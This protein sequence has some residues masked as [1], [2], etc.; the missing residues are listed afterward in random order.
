MSVSFMRSELSSMLLVYSIIRDCIEGEPAIKGWLLSGTN[1][2]QNPAGFNGGGANPVLSDTIL[3]RARR[4]LPMPNETDQSQ[5]NK[6]RY[7]QYLQRAVWYNVTARTLEGMV[8]QIFLIPPVIEVPSELKPMLTDSDGDGLSFVQGAKKS[9]SDTMAYGRCGLYVD[10]PKTSGEVNKAQISSGAIKPMIQVI[11]P[12]NIYNWRTKKINGKTVLT[13]VVIRE[14]SDNYDEDGYS[15]DQS[16]GYRVL[17]LDPSTG[18]YTIEV[19]EPADARDGAVNSITDPMVA[20]ALPSKANVAYNQSDTIVP[21]DGAGKPFTYIPFTFVGSKNNDPA[22]DKP[23]LYDLASLNLAHYR[24]SADFE[25]SCHMVGQPTP[26]ATGLDESWVHNVLHDSIPLG[27]RAGIPLPTGA[28]IG[29]MQAN[30]NQMPLEAM[31]AKEDEMFALGAKLVVQKRVQ[32]TATEAAVDAS[33][34]TS[35]LTNVAN[36]VSTAYEFAF[37]CAAQFV[38]A[39]ASKIKVALNTQFELN[40]LTPDEQSKVVASWVQGAISFGEMRET[41]RKA[42]T[43]TLPDDQARAAIEKDRKDGLIPPAGGAKLATNAPNPNNNPSGHADTAA[44]AG[45]P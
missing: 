42:G 25:E 3:L 8:G 30:A 9:V 35:V 38:N 39:D 18:N 43:A 14:V 2:T 45:R 17:K 22:V 21:T 31:K 12:W 29:L 36:N 19:Y 10:Y 44:A 33:S 11:Q 1:I 40:T 32:R 16:E 41:L 13:M 24:N 15:V 27:S 26:W 6:D 5:K 4:Y 34:E 28:Q 23:P 20:A 7:R 37:K